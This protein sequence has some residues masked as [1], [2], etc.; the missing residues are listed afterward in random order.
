MLIEWKLAPPPVTLIFAH[1]GRKKQGAN[2][3]G[4]EHLIFSGKCVLFGLAVIG[5]IPLTTLFTR[6]DQSLSCLRLSAT[7][8]IAACQASLSITNSWS[9]LRLTSI[10]S[11]MPSSHLILCR[12]FLLLHPIPPSIRVFSSELVHIRWCLC[13]HGI[14]LSLRKSKQLH[15]RP[16][17]GSYSSLQG[18]CLHPN[19][20]TSFYTSGLCPV[21]STA[22]PPEAW[23]GWVTPEQSWVA[24]CTDTKGH[25]HSRTGPKRSNSLSVPLPSHF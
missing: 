23:A 20:L 13:C 9:S 17:G 21:T 12:P 19:S 10:E 22:L 16:R 4:L 7:P 25:A 11:A 14:F 8:W 1:L 15:V 18:S 24:G 5:Y 6:S 3:E 2:G